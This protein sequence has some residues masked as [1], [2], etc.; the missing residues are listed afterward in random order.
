MKFR[1]LSAVALVLVS[2]LATVS[3]TSC[4]GS[5]GSAAGVRIVA[6][7]NVYGSI[8]QSIAGD[9]ATITS[10]I[11][12]PSQD[13]HSFEAG[14]R[15]QLEISK[16]DVIIV[17]G[18]GYDDFVDR[19][20]SG[21]GN[22]DAVVIRAVDFSRHSTKALVSNEH[23][24]YDFQAMTSMAA[25]LVDILSRI[26]PV[27]EDQYRANNQKFVES[28]SLLQSDIAAIAVEH[29]GETV[30]MTEP[31]PGYLL[32]DAGLIDITPA[33]LST[34]IEDGSGVPPAV[35]ERALALI[36]SGEVSLL[37]VNEQTEG[38]ETTQLLAAATQCGVPILTVQET[39]P[40]GLNY[41]GWMAA[42]V[43]E[44]GEALA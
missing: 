32:A 18:G 26:D 21:A 41:L 34:A 2:S 15:V 5:S 35:L 23:V 22:K 10:I 43:R 44:L 8:A 38:P 30:L 33:A 3:L 9:H 29:S 17:N 11:G 36:R 25:E 39:V 40:E 19:L 12:S 14:A 31:V 4:A 7:T 6:S 42:T 37:A 28:M 1:S 20:L 24:W 13:P 27:N 16:A